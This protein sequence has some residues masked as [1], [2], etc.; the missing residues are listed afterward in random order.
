MSKGGAVPNTDCR[1]RVNRTKMF[2]MMAVMVALMISSFVVISDSEETDGAI[3]GVTISPSTLQIEVE[4]TNILYAEID[5]EAGDSV[6]YK[7]TVESGGT[8]IAIDGDDDTSSV[9]IKAKTVTGSAQVKVTVR[10]GTVTKTATC[11]ITVYSVKADKTTMTLNEGEKSTFTCTISPSTI[12]HT[13]TFSLSKEDVV[14]L[15]TSGDSTEITGVKKGSVDVTAKVEI[16]N[17]T[18]TFTCKVT[19][20]HVAVQQLTWNQGDKSSDISLSVDTGTNGKLSITIIPANASNKNITWTTSDPN[21]VSINPV[22]GQ[23]ELNYKALKAGKAIITATSV[24]ETSVKATCTITVSDVA[25]KSITLDE[26]DAYVEVDSLNEISYTLD[27]INATVVTEKWASSDTSILKIDEDTGI[28]TGVKPGKATVT[29]TLGNEHGTKTAS[30]EVLV[31]TTKKLY[32]ETT[33]DSQGHAQVTDSDGLIK[34][35]Q[36]AAKKKLDPVLVIEAYNSTTLTMPS[37]LVKEIQKA[38]NGIM[39]VG[40]DYGAMEFDDDCVDHINVSGTNVKITFDKVTPE[41]ETKYDPCYIYKISIFK[42]DSEIDTAFGSDFLKVG[43]Y[44]ELVGDEKAED[45]KVAYLDKDGNAVLLRHYSY[46][47]DY[48]A[49]MF[50]AAK[51]SQFMFLFHDADISAGEI[52]TVAAIVFL[53]LV[54][55][56]AGLTVYLILNPRFSDIFNGLFDKNNRPPKQPRQPR[57]PWKFRKQQQ[58]P[59]QDQ[60]Y[61]NYGGNN[62]R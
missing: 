8:S 38:N 18:Y 62:Y 4:K 30:I 56:L 42:D 17:K 59:Y 31:P 24:S 28:M 22:S 57:K 55:G 41:K 50:M 19:V 48:G 40:M 21:I 16:G 27:P 60:Y 10:D 9:M 26:D 14:T 29:V 46:P 58:D 6:T 23:P 34:E 5:G 13:T 32:A 15:K 35:I 45:L 3:T 51:T 37:A 53:V 61:N 12:Q 25:I 43:I 1:G 54:I 2:L 11:S 7:W 44:H 49:V 33:Q 52:N 36:E 39:Y 20:I 47:E